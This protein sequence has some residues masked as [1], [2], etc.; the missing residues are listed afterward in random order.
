MMM[1]PGWEDHYTLQYSQPRIPASSRKSPDVPKTLWE[2]IIQAGPGSALQSPSCRT[3]LIQIYQ[4]IAVRCPNHLLLVEQWPQC[5]FI[6]LIKIVILSQP[7]NPA[8]PAPGHM[9]LFFGHYPRLIG[10]KRKVDALSA[11]SWFTK[12]LTL[13]A[14]TLIHLSV[15][16]SINRVF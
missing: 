14:L 6:Q 1:A 9:T 3:C 15:S 8:F 7:C 5:T 11:S 16:F 2:I 10:K 12:T 4:G 13:L